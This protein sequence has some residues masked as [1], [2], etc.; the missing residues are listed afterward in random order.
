MKSR[1][2]RNPAGSFPA[3][4]DHFSRVPPSVHRLREGTTLFPVMQPHRLGEHVPSQSRAIAVLA[5]ALFADERCRE[6]VGTFAAAS[7]A[8][9]ICANQLRVAPI[10]ED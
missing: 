6:F 10:L 7:S 1:L 5:I 8:A 2:D 3:T 4:G 9:W